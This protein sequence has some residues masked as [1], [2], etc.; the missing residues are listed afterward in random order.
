MS[1]GGTNTTTTSSA[2]PAD[3]SAAYDTVAGQ[4]EALDQSNLGAQPYPGQ[5][6][7]NMP[8]EEQTGISNIQNNAADLQPYL[9][10]AQ[11]DLSSATQPLW[12]SVQQFSPS[13]ISEYESPYTSDVV[14][15]AEQQFNNQ[16][17]IQQTGIVGNAVAQGAF[18]GD[19]SAVAQA[20]TAGQQQANEA[21]VIAGLENTGYTN[22]QG[23]FNTQ[24]QNQLGANEAN[25]WLSSQASSQAANL[26]QENYN[27]DLGT[28]QGMIQGG[29]LDQQ[30]QQA[31]LNVPYE[32]YVQAQS[33]P[34]QALNQEANILE[35]LGGASGGTSSTTS[36]AASPLS[37]VAGVGVG[38][39]GLLGATGAFGSSGYLTGAGGLFGSSADAG[40]AGGTIAQDV[41]FGAAAG[42]A[43]PARGIGGMIPLTGAPPMG[44]G[45]LGGS[46]VPDVS[47]SVVPTG[48]TGGRNA[49]FS[50]MGTPG[51]T[52][53][54]TG[55]GSGIA[56]ALG[57][58]AGIAKIGSMFL[59][60]GGAVDS[61]PRGVI[62]R[63]F[64]A[65]RD[66][67]GFVPT[68]PYPNP[69]LP[70][71]AIPQVGLSVVPK[72]GIAGHGGMGPPKAPQG[73]AP[74]TSPGAITGAQLGQWG[75]ALK[76]SG[77]FS[78]SVPAGNARGGGIV[79]HYDDGGP[80]DP[81]A[82]L[83][84]AAGV[85]PT[86]MATLQ[87]AGTLGPQTAS[88]PIS[89]PVS[90]GSGIAPPSSQVADLPAASDLALPSS[91]APVADG[92]TISTPD[93]G[94]DSKAPASL[95]KGILAREGGSP[96]AVSPKG[97]I[98]TYQIMPTTGAPYMQ[99]GESLY[100]PKVN[101]RVGNSIIN[102]LWSKYH[103]PQ[104]VMVA[105][106]AG[107]GVAD[108]WLASGRDSSVLPGETQRYIG[109]AP[110]GSSARTGIAGGSTNPSG[111]ISP[112]AGGSSSVSP[113]VSA[114]GVSPSVSSG[115]VPS[116][117]PDTSAMDRL[118][119]GS[120]P[121]PWLALAAAGFGMAAGNSPHALQ[122]IG[123]GALEGVKFLE[124]ERQNQPELR[125]KNAQA[126]QAEAVAAKTVGA[127]QAF[128]NQNSPSTQDLHDN[129][130]A[131][132][133]GIKA[134]ENSGATQ[135]P[136][137]VNP[138]AVAATGV[139]PRQPANSANSA[140]PPPQL[141]TADSPEV[142]LAKQ[143]LQQEYSLIG[144][145]A[146]PAAAMSQYV[147]HLQAMPGFQG[148]VAGAEAA[149]KVGPAITQAGGEAAAK[150]P[151]ATSSVR[152]GGTALVGGQPVYTAPIQRSIVDPTTGREIMDWATPPAPGQTGTGGSAGQTATGAPGSGNGSYVTK[153]GPGEN[154]SLEKR[155]DD[156]QEVRNETLKAAQA[157]QN[158]LSTLNV[159]KDN[160][161]NMY[162]GP[163]ASYV[164]DFNKVARLV[165]PAY[166]DTVAARESFQK[167]GGQLIRQATRELSPRAA[168]QEVQFVQSTLPNQD[169][170]PKGL[171]MVIGELQGQSDYQIAKAKAQSAWE[172]NHGGLGH[173]EG[174]EN[175]WQSN[176]P[177]T[178]YTFI[179]NRM[180]QPARQ[181]LFAKWNGTAEGR[182][183]LQKMRTQAQ[184]ATANGLFQ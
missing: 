90:Y 139:P 9:G 68:G 48:T 100:D 31:E 136:L 149:A 53:T 56:G 49:A 78:N 11:G 25:A 86:T 10:E 28:E 55:G 130:A 12:S 16:N 163:G 33:Y 108:K 88:A 97:A 51:A 57:D 166:D 52:S 65:R 176:A 110:T 143:R 124:S 63:P 79:G 129:I 103:D 114:S 117:A 145:A 36:P 41:G 42:G 133:G 121:N 35:G 77:L 128:Q 24:Q 181:A 162:V 71:G 20:I 70:S 82:A 160:A 178:P 125:L 113:N 62:G 157:A 155:A 174:F 30:Q 60:D 182:Q 184:Y 102:D 27:A 5:I 38:G 23:E 58:I 115:I 183:E 144:F 131:V 91:G 92:V 161:S 4:A 119:K 67:G 54:T 152:P 43:I 72:T 94:D 64:L 116:A 150:F 61:I 69:L 112:S 66:D 74:G 45:I 137:P 107:P 120:A 167:N 3:V 2:P 142:R 99:K 81:D 6:V 173:V 134:G 95:V 171:S 104:A 156:E 147:T 80:V 59:A 39:L 135:A 168:Y 84:Q 93:S 89:P 148:Q 101:E 22:A 26:G 170:S 7:A 105:Y 127:M 172:G 122:N 37:Q 75:T 140:P 158:Q 46:S 34:Y 29:T 179:V 169:M 109:A 106:N 32:Q 98:G 96:D 15:S 164:G 138:G 175:D 151:Y 44:A 146:D 8:A 83:L 85:D 165:N 13:A 50:P 19:R 159:L 141:T 21:P 73:I 132:S 17:A 40:S 154:V 111:G 76:Q 126:T 118:T 177:V 87:R 153:L 123:A 1:S 47:M 180:D 18:G 14:N